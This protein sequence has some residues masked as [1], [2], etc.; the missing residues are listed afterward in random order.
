[1]SGGVAVLLAALGIILIIAGIRGTYSDVALAL[2]HPVNA[3]GK[4][5]HAPGTIDPSIPGVGGGA[6]GKK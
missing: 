1:M 6:G 4:E 5:A 2:L 3:P